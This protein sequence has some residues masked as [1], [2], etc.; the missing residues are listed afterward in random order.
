[1][2]APTGLPAFEAKPWAYWRGVFKNW[3]VLDAWLDDCVQ[4]LAIRCW[5]YPN[6]RLNVMIKQIAIDFF[7][8]H[9]R[10][11]LSFDLLDVASRRDEFAA[12]EARLDAN[13]L[14]AQ[15]RPSELRGIC[16]YV[17]RDPGKS[18]NTDKVALYKA[19]QHLRELSV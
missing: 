16:R 3:R 6:M 7:D 14:F 17:D 11:S 13:A 1:L 2:Y 18:T 10:D 15:L 9:Y 12:V 5:R 19:R 4:Q 8:M